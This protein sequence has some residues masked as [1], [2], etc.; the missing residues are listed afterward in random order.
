MTRTAG[1]GPPKPTATSPLERRL[2]KVERTVKKL[3]RLLAKRDLPA[4]PETGAD[5]DEGVDP[6]LGRH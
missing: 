6:F 5:L 3:Q 2:A 1:S 4:P